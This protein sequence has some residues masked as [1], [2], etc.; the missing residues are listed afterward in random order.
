MN[1]S[2]QRA[3]ACTEPGSERSF[4]VR[5]GR[6]G[7]VVTVTLDRPGSPETRG[8]D[9]IRTLSRLGRNLPG[10]VRV[11]VVD[12]VSLSVAGPDVDL[13][14]VDPWEPLATDWLR[15]PDV[16]SIAIIRDQATGIGSQIALACDLRV[17][18]SAARLVVDEVARGTVPSFGSTKRLVDLVG[19][20]R[21]LD[22]CV[23]GRSISAREAEHFGLATIVASP[24]Q[25]EDAVSDLVG[26]V[27]SA[28]RDAVVEVKALL[29]GASRRT[30]SQQEEAER[31]AAIRLAGDWSSGSASQDA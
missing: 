14:G 11:V 18:S 21:A 15:R 23:T 3:T 22:L 24:H 25:L 26:R 1:P 5:F 31:A 8:A 6:A 30:L 7:P 2:P 9:V 4:G 17:W 28:D 12:G 27:L 10:D 19:Y 20:A 16:I 13:D 29:F